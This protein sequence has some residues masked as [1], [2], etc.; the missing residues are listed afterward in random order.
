M[1]WNPFRKT[2][3]TR[4]EDLEFE[5]EVNRLRQMQAV[6]K[7][8]YKDMRK[9]NDSETALVRAGQKVVSDIKNSPLGRSEP[10]KHS[11]EVLGGMMEELATHSRTLKNNQEVTFTEPIKKFN[12]VYKHVEF[13]AKQRELKLQEFE[14]QQAKL[15][16]LER[17]ATTQSWTQGAALQAKL[18]QTQRALSSARSD[19]D[20][21]HSRMMQEMPELYEG[22]VGYFDLCL[23]AVI[24]S[25][26]LHYQDCSR[27]LHAGLTKLQG[28]SEL[29]SE[30]EIAKTTERHLAD[31]RALSIVGAAPGT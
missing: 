31:I 12:N 11:A 7:R 24:K 18:E 20:R 27:T 1:S 29:M 5:R 15:E 13:H 8:M 17:K 6:S 14:K 4:T 3:R 23:Q 9:C 22:R 25:Q 16:K 26:A 21:V 10:L 2:R 30:E 19:Y 28:S